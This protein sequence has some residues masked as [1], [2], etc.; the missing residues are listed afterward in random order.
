MSTTIFVRRH[1]T[2]LTK[3][4]IAL[5]IA[6]STQAELEAASAMDEVL[7]ELF[8]T[9]PLFSVFDIDR[10]DRDRFR[11]LF[12]ASQDARNRYESNGPNGPPPFDSFRQVLSVWDE[13]LQMMR[14]DERCSNAVTLD[15]TLPDRPAEPPLGI[16]VDPL[17]DIPP[18]VRLQLC[19]F[20]AKEWPPATPHALYEVGKTRL[21]KFGKQVALRAVL[22]AYEVFVSEE[23][24]SDYDRS[25]R[26]AAERWVLEP[27]EENR[28]TAGRIASVPLPEH[29]SARVIAN[30]AG[31]NRRWPSAVGYALTLN[32]HT[33]QEST[34]R[35][36]CAGIHAE[37]LAW[38]RGEADPVAERHRGA[39]RL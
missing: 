6:A 14:S 37:L 27:S 34:F 7:Q 35:R 32:P 24:E 9:V 23:R 3:N 19:D 4:A 1:K 39:G 36:V 13:L 2:L 31:S 10:L 12:V 20:L 33:L 22:A 38:A 16:V 15:Q 21:A 29:S 18:H 5:T 17:K 25:A 28:K 30:M 26:R 8:E 11:K